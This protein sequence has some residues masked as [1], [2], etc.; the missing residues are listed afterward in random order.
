MTPIYLDNNATTRA[1]PEVVEAMLHYLTDRYGNPSSMH[2]AGSRASAGLKGARETAAAFLSCREAEIVFT[3]G[4]TESNNTAIRGVIDTFA[5]KRHIVT[6]RVEHP[7]VLEVCRQL[8]GSGYPVTYLGVDRDGMLD[9]SELE[10]AI[11]DRTVLVTIMWANNETGVV[12]PIDEIAEI[13]RRRGV[14]LHVD[15][16][17]AAGKI[18]IDLGKTPIDLLTLSG[19]KLH[20][21]KG[22]GLLFVRREVR[23]RPLIVGGG[24]ERG[25]RSGTE[26]LP[27][28][29]G[30]G[31][32]FELVAEQM[33][34][35]EENIRRLRDRF[36]TAILSSVPDSSRNG[37]PEPRLPNTSHIR[38]EG[39][40]GEAVLL[41]LDEAGVFASSGSACSTGALEPSHVLKAMG[42]SGAAA[43]SAVR[44]SLSRYTTEEE[45]ERVI[46]ILPGIVR[47][48]RNVAGAGRGA[49]PSGA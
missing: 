26:N 48:L 18:P 49:G 4:G 42:V 17:Q 23:V 22:V 9:L 25:R 20:A 11:T 45:I 21:P 32:A 3:S 13:T 8:E 16:V 44:F 35:A 27:G 12:F 15:G 29:V 33:A 28:I 37:A 41:L 1:A 24:Q 38:F 46:E 30:F 47:R 14:L 36:E 5:E 39:V 2:R 7:S 10:E 31:K 19:H 34:S 43:L 6:T 40:E